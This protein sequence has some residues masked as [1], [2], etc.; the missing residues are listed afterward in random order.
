MI[1]KFSA[2]SFASGL[3]VLLAAPT[4]GAKAPVPPRPKAIA[5]PQHKQSDTFVLLH[6][7]LNHLQLAYN[8][9]RSADEDKEGHK[10]QA[11][12]AVDNAMNEVRAALKADYPGKKA[13]ASAREPQR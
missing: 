12:R 8:D 9:L 7:A 10:T 2:F 5:S 1:R 6:N 11:E 13:S 4:F 3:L